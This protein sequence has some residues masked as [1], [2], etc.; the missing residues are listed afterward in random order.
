[1]NAEDQVVCT[2]NP[3]FQGLKQLRIRSWIFHD[4]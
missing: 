1:M 2:N 3:P 4:Q